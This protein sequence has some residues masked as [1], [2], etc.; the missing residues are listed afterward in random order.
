MSSFTASLAEAGSR[1]DMAMAERLGW[2]RS[3]VQRFIKA[4]LVTVN[5]KAANRYSQ[6]VREGDRIEVVEA[7]AVDVVVPEVPILYQDD[8]L[9][10]IDKPAGLLVHTAAAKPEATVAEAVRG[11]VADDDPLRPG[12]VHR[13]DKDTSGALIIARTAA[14]KEYL[15]RL[16]RQREVHKTYL[17][18]TAGHP[19]PA[20]AVIDLPLG[21]GSSASGRRVVNPGGRSAQT[22]YQTIASYP[23][24]AL[25]EVEPQTGRTHQIRAHLQAIG[26]PIAG[27]RLYGGPHVP[28]LNRQ[29]LHASRLEFTGPNGQAINVTSQLPPDLAAVLDRLGGG[30]Y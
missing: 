6:T 4:G 8:D 16:F 2:S 14:A 29:F 11:L 7:P 15:Q 26:H 9:L 5:T 25:L 17:A 1:L 28:G 18:L 21:S 13:L 20:R 12:I 22:R 24:Y 30:V 10:V 27:D 3:Q 23:G 19:Q